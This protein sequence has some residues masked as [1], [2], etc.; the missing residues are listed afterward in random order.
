MSV[1][2]QAIKEKSV[3][4]IWGCGDYLKGTID[5]I[6]ETINIQYLCD[7]DQ[8]K[9]N[10]TIV[11]AGRELV[12]ES[13]QVLYEKSDVI[14][15][16]AT[17]SSIV[18]GKIETAVKELGLQSCHINDA[19]LENIHKWDEQQIDKYDREMMNIQEPGATD[20]IKCF[21]SVSVPIDFCN[22]RCHYCY[23]GQQN[24]FYKKEAIYHSPNFIRRALSRKRIGGT[25]LINFCGTGETFLC[26]ELPGIIKEL[27]F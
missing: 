1:F 22:L 26:K 16:I 18:E 12:C 27:L 7:T 17:Q 4:A 2:S 6:E 21:I 19:I 3:F 24:C 25:A 20:S 10:T 8:S 13:P 9:W 14:V 23:V 5:I 11:Y 15:L